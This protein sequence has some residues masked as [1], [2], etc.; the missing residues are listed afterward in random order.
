MVRTLIKKAI[1]DGLA[2]LRKKTLH[3]I[4]VETAIKWCGRA[5]AAALMGRVDDAEEYAH[6][7]IEHAALS[8]D[9]ALLR[10]VREALRQCGVELFKGAR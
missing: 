9:D 2:E 8:G 10:E 5:C 3:Q 1:D 7:A 4:Q 6:E